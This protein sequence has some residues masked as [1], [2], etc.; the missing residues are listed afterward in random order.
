M[1]RIVRLTYI[2]D[3]AGFALNN[4]YDRCGR[5]INLT[6]NFDGFAFPIL[7]EFSGVHVGASFAFFLIT[8]RRAISGLIW[9]VELFQSFDFNVPQESG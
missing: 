5:T 6:L 9:G 3:T 2:S 4:V 1:D 7:Y 8:R